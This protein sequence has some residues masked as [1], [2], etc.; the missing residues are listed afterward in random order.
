MLFLAETVRIV[1]EYTHFIPLIIAFLT[2]V[3]GPISLVFVKHKLFRKDK[4]IEKRKKD[5]QQSL[6]IQ[7]LINKSLNNLQQKFNLDRLWIAQF[8][9]GGNFWPGNKS[10]KKMS[11]TFESTAPGVSTDLMKMQNLPV[12]FLYPIFKKLKYND[13]KG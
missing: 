1:P 10:M 3:L 5:F 8:H 4:E 11:M 9:N 13:I 2:G 12:S 6:E 7:D